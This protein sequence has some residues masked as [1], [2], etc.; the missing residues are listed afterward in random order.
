MI[1]LIEYRRSVSVVSHR[2]SNKSIV[3]SAVTIAVL[4]S[5]IHIRDAL[6]RVLNVLRCCLG[7]P[8]VSNVLGHVSL[9]YFESECLSFRISNVLV[10]LKIS[11][12]NWISA[13][14]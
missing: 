9:C 4:V 10:H 5:R 2:A 14:K 11:F 3:L 7:V 6:V 8:K 13:R 1:E 12:E